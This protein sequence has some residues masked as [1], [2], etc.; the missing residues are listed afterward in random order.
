MKRVARML[1]KCL[2]TVNCLLSTT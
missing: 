2:V 1:L